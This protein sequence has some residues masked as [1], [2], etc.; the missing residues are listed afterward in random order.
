MLAAAER[1]VYPRLPLDVMPSSCTI[2]RPPILIS[3]ACL[4][5]AQVQLAGC[6]GYGTTGSDVIGPAA[7][8]NNSTSNTPPKINAPPI[9]VRP[10]RRSAAISQDVSAANTG[11]RLN[12]T[13]V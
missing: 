9:N 13:A 10:P 7:G 6:R 1:S 5:T 8:P 11:S 12:S 2:D 4:L 3:L